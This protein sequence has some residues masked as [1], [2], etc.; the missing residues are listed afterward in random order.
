VTA[1]G[2][3]PNTIRLVHRAT[4]L[5]AAGA[6]ALAGIAATASAAGAADDIAAAGEQAAGVVCASE[7]HGWDVIFAGP[8]QQS[9]QW[10]FVVSDMV[11]RGAQANDEQ[12]RL[13]RHFL[14]RTWGEVWIN[15]ANAQDLVAVLALPDKDAEAVI[16]YRQEHGRFADLASLKKVPGVD[17]AAI[18]AQADAIVFN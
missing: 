7:C 16:A 5:V 13:I 12:L 15:S 3:I 2:H 18:D 9:G 6:I 10:D 14:K 4:Q 1:L 11:G 17:L 8:R